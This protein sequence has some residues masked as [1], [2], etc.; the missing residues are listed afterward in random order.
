MREE[1]AIDKLL[2]LGQQ[3][4]HVTIDQITRIL[5]IASMSE[6]EISRAVQRL[7]EAGV[8]VEIDEEWTA[9]RRDGAAG[10]PLPPA[11][12]APEAVLP[13]TN[14]TTGKRPHS[15]TMGVGRVVPDMPTG[16]ARRASWLPLAVLAFV[17]VALLVLLGALD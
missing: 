5:P 12:E 11:A 17:A 15:V 16:S 10:G 13:P 4:G 2:R 1:A 7:E 8:P 3:Q 14:S 9:D 6:G